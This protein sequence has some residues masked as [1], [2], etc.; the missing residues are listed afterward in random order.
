MEIIFRP[1]HPRVNV[2]DLERHLKTIV[3][4][5]LT[6][7]KMSFSFPRSLLFFSLSFFLS[8]FLFF[9]NIEQVHQR[10]DSLCIPERFKIVI[11][12]KEVLSKVQEM[13]RRNRG[14]W[15]G[16]LG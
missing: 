4:R 8:F 1:S 15:D 11:Q 7:V 2:C 12:K 10:I 5:V 14:I 3:I 9:P 6:F 16:L 13:P